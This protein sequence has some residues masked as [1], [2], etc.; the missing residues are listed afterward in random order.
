MHRGRLCVCAFVCVH[1]CM[2]VCVCMGARV[3]DSALKCFLFFFRRAVFSSVSDLSLSSF[4]LLLSVRP[5]SPL[6]TNWL[7]LRRTN[8]VTGALQTRDTL[9]LRS[10]NNSGP[11]PIFS[12][13]A[14]LIR[15]EECRINPHKRLMR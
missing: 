15:F 7:P 8:S 11:G 13:A 3:S 2:C 1:V 10:S 5:T 4:S 6:S 14:H 9:L 12:D